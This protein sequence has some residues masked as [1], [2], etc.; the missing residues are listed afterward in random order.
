MIDTLELKRMMTNASGDQKT[1]LGNIIKGIAMLENENRSLRTENS[2][3]QKQLS[4]SQ[5]K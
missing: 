2:N 3:L 1:V 4:E 5:A